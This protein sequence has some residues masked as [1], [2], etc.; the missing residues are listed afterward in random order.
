MGLLSFLRRQSAD[1]INV[2]PLYIAIVDQARG[3]AFYTQLGV[4]DTLDGRFDMIIMH[5]MMVMRRLRV[6]GKQVEDMTQALLDYMFNDMD[7]SLREIGIG[8]M[9][10][11]KHVKKMAKAF[12][13]RAEQYEI[14]M[15]GTATALSD[16][17]KANL[18]RGAPPTNEQLATMSAYM[19]ASDQALRGFALADITQGHLR[20]ASIDGRG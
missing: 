12:Y 6:E 17:L 14:G 3:S 4:P 15:D 16:A 8:D 13:G 10:V 18:Y 11:G 5:T 9:S 20:W 2:G 19:L 1:N 7:R